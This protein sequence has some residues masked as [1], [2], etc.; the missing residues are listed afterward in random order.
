[1]TLSHTI[2]LGNS[3][4]EGVATPDPDHGKIKNSAAKYKV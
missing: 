2:N 4:Q 3:A 1:M